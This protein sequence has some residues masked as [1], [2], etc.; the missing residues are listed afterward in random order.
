MKRTPSNAY[1]IGMPPAVNMGAMLQ[2]TFGAAPSSLIVIPLG[3]PVVTENKPQATIMDHKPMANILPFGV[4][5]APTNP[6]GMAKPVV[7]TPCPCVPVVPAPWT[8]MAPTVMVNNK[9]ILVKGAVAMCIWAGV[10]QV[11]NPGAL[12]TMAK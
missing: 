7:P 2:C 11:Q 9:P 3:P 4:C 6:A 5:N 12:K 1:R 8:P 10:I